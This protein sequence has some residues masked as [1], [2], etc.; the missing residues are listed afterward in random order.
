MAL[1][2]ESKV[3]DGEQNMTNAMEGEKTKNLEEMT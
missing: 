1:I 3:V 2:D